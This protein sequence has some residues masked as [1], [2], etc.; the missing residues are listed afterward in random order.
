[1]DLSSSKPAIDEGEFTSVYAEAD[2][3]SIRSCEATVN[4]PLAGDF[5]D[6]ADAESN[7][8]KNGSP[9]EKQ[10]STYKNFQQED[11]G[12]IIQS[13]IRR[14]LVNTFSNMCINFMWRFTCE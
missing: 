1:D 12:M 8:V 2:R 3:A 4:Q 7:E 10:N 14:F 5:K 13:A 11:A 6:K 9:K